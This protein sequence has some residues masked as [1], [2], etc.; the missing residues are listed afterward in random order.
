MLLCGVNESAK[1]VGYERLVPPNVFEA[2]VFVIIYDFDSP[3]HRIRSN[4]KWIPVAESLHQS[5][6]PLEFLWFSLRLAAFGTR[7]M[8]V[9]YTNNRPG[10]RTHKPFPPQGFGQ[11]DSTVPSSIHGYLG[12][13]GNEGSGSC[14]S[15]ALVFRSQRWKRSRWVSSKSWWK[16]HNNAVDTRRL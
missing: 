3:S 9:R 8:V 4:V 2:T 11:D 13:S 14:R 10:N 5:T 16:E 12:G 6:G 1:R 7:L 15:P